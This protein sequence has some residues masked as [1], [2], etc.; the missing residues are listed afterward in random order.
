MGGFQFVKARNSAT[1]WHCRG[2]ADARIDTRMIFI[3][4]GFRADRPRLLEFNRRRR[5]ERRWLACQWSEHPSAN[6]KMSPRLRRPES[7]SFT[8]KRDLNRPSQ[9]RLSD[10]PWAIRDEYHPQF[11]ELGRTRRR[12]LVFHRQGMPRAS[13]GRPGALTAPADSHIRAEDA[14]RHEECKRS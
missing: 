12:L 4:C 3:G 10:R 2:M 1:A 14:G 7:L 8:P 11:R 5:F 13:T 9:P 6:E